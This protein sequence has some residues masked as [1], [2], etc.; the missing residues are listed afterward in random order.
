M[1][2]ISRRIIVI[3]DKLEVHYVLFLSPCDL[4]TY[5]TAYFTSVSL[6]RLLHVDIM[7]GSSASCEPFNTLDDFQS[8]DAL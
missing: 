1:P 7:T 4:K 6:A 8:F 2:I 3:C 5:S